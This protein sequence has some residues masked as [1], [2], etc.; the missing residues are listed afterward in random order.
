MICRGEF[1]RMFSNS[2]SFLTIH[3]PQQI[4]A[5][6][7]IQTLEIFFSLINPPRCYQGF[8]SRPKTSLVIHQAKMARGHLNKIWLVVS[9]FLH[10]LQNSSPPLQ[11][12]LISWEAQGSLFLPTK[13]RKSLIFNSTPPSF[14]Y[15]TPPKVIILY[16]DLVEKVFFL[17][18]GHATL[19]LSSSWQPIIK[20]FNPEAPFISAQ[21]FGTH[22]CFP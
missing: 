2:Q 12:L 10:S 19:S 8:F 16:M 13:S 11:L 20:L 22:V 7:T 3:N 15:P 6:N 1:T 5:T 14:L 21:L 18:C 4:I 17:L 9:I